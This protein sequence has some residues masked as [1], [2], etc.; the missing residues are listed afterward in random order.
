MIRRLE[1]LKME[2]D[3]NF[4]LLLNGSPEG[5]KVDLNLPL[6]DIPATGAFDRIMQ[7]YFDYYYEHIG[8]KTFII[9][10]ITWNKF[11]HFIW[12]PKYNTKDYDYKTWYQC[13]LGDSGFINSY[14]NKNTTYKGGIGNP[15]L[16]LY[17]GDTLYKLNKG[18][19]KKYP[20]LHTFLERMVDYKGWN[21]VMITVDNRCFI[22][23]H[24]IDR[25]FLAK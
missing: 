17:S 9:C 4:V 25:I 6:F 11:E 8:K 18:Q 23:E 13:L 12:T 2:E 1:K 15:H 22:Q 24:H 16:E 20:S 14:L 5:Q 3:N 19:L 10:T 7:T 21:V